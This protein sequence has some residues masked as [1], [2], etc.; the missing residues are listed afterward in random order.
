MQNHLNRMCSR[1]TGRQVVSQEIG[2]SFRKYLV[3]WQE[4]K[5]SFTESKNSGAIMANLQQLLEYFECIICG[6]SGLDASFLLAEE[7]FCQQRRDFRQSH[8]HIGNSHIISSWFLE[9]SLVSRICVLAYAMDYIGRGEVQ[10]FHS[11]H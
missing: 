8:L 3:R 1:I 6:N 9:T 10:K 7:Y 5:N 11:T 4:C 2:A